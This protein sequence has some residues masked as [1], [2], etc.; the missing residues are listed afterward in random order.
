MFRSILPVFCAAFFTGCEKE[1]RRPDHYKVDLFADE[2]QEGK[3]YV[4]D[5]KEC[6]DNSDMVISSSALKLTDSSKGRGKP[7]FIYK[8]NSGELLKTTRDSVVEYPLEFISPQKLKF[9]KDSSVYVYLKKLE[10]YRF[11]AKEKNLKYQWLRGASVY[12]VQK[13]K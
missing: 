12:S 1:Y 6:F 2:R 11:L 8:I 3:A 4:M 13:D 5:R 7:V 10:G 9:R